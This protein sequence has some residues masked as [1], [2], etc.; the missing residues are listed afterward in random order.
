ML[1][2]SA[3]LLSLSGVALT[4]CDAGAKSNE[5]LCWLQIFFRYLSMNIATRLTGAPMSSPA[6]PF[7]KQTSNLEMLNCILISQDTSSPHEPTADRHGYFCQLCTQKQKRLCML[8]T[9]TPG[10]GRP[11]TSRYWSYISFSGSRMSRSHNIAERYTFAVG[12]L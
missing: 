2:M 3:A 12:Y 4:F 7:V 9:L 1:P 10:L 6:L 8:T 11:F 5:R